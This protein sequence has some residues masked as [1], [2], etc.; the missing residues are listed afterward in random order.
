MRSLLFV[1]ADS[2]KKL[3]RALSSGADALILDLE[4]SVAAANKDEA[5]RNIL[6]FLREHRERNVRPRLYARIN[7]FDT[8][9]SEGDLDVV[10]TAAP[11]GIMLPKAAGGPDV[12]LLD[13]RLAVR[14]ALHG[15]PD[16]RTG[17][18]AIA[19]ETASAVFNLGT[20]A[21][22][23]GRLEGIA[24]GAE[25]LSADIG[26]LASRTDGTWTEPFR[27]VRSLCLFGAAA[28]GVLAIDTVHVNFRDSEGLQRECR[29]ALRDGFDGKLA[30]HPDQV[31]IINEAFT[32]TAEALAHAEKVVA[33]FDAEAGV[34]A[35]DGRMTDRPH[36]KAAQRVLA[37][38]RGI[39]NGLPRDSAPQS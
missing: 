39:A 31:P 11:D 25:D 14:E 22:S 12:M 8:E 35:L 16:G 32:P 18:L 20:Y 5:R 23:S 37:R 10:M 33:A 24:W 6:G 2:P 27:L 26:A 38:A 21:G 15:E 19:S 3:A 17:I 36:L 28:A 7:G 4:D 13:A 30:I 1:P 34:V 9:L 29:E